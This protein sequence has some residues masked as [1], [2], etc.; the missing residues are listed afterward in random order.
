M[1]DR[2]R[3]RSA[4]YTVGYCKPPTHSRFK[5]GQSGNPKGRPKG[6]RNLKTD[7]QSELGGLITVTEN[8]QR[9]RISRQ[10]AI[11]RRHSLKAME[12]DHKAALLLFNMIMRLSGDEDIA[13]I[14]PE[15]ITAEDAKLIER[16]EQR[17]HRRMRA[18]DP[19]KKK[20]P[21]Q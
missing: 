11:L 10:E 19:G 5:P 4:E 20:E 13:P 8:G 14:D 18:T 2:K 16:L 1:T 21:K 3:R 7:L 12:G 9:R 15:A 17:I 6:T